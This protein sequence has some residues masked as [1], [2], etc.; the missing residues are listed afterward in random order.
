MSQRYIQYTEK[1]DLNPGATESQIAKA[2]ADLHVSFPLD[3]LEFM[4]FS[5]GVE[6]FVGHQY[7]ELWRI[8]DLQAMNAGYRVP[9]FLPDFLMFGSDG[10]GTG[11]VFDLR[12]TAM[13]VMAVEQA[14]L[15]L[16]EVQPIAPTF[17]GLMQILLNLSK[18]KSV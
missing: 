4:Q 13:P 12:T 2:E 16:D 3:Y 15:N 14:A 17:F 8:E 6:G 18:G 5:N 11:Y 7:L 9:E 1:L 10:G